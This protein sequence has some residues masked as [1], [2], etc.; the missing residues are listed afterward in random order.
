[1]SVKGPEHCAF[2]KPRRIGSARI[3]PNPAQEFAD[4][5]LGEFA[6]IGEAPVA[7]GVSILLAGG[8]IWRTVEWHFKTRLENSASTQ[9]LLERQLG[10]YR[11]K[12]D[13]A[14]PQEARAKIEA[15]EARVNAL[16]GPRLTEDQKNKIRPWLAAHRGNMVHLT[17][18][19]AS[20]QAQVF[21]RQMSDLFRQ[22]GWNVRN[23]MVLGIGNPPK[24]GL[25][26]MVTNPQQLTPAQQAISEG[27]TAAGIKFDLQQGSNSGHPANNQE[28]IA[29][30]LFT[31]AFDS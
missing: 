25:A 16:E 6:V 3:M 26:L 8:L 14:S 11:D 13:G 29:Q 18:D 30:L 10:D 24:S 21:C 27:L 28:P 9:T 22:E 4:Y 12:L 1:M 2:D 17:Q 23:P 5:I 7:F 15:L 19:S 20:A 31:T